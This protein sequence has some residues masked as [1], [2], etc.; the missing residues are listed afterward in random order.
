MRRRLA[1]AL[2]LPL[3]ILAGCSERDD[4]AAY[5]PERQQQL[6]GTWALTEESTY[7]AW[8]AC[9][10]GPGAEVPLTPKYRKIRDDFANI[11]ANDKPTPNNLAFCISPGVPG[12]FEHP[13]M[14]EFLLT[15]GRV[16]LIFH[17]GSF[18]RIWTDGRSFPESLTPTLQGYSIGRWEKNVLIV[19]TR[20]ISKKSDIFIEGYIKATNRTK[21]TERFAFESD[22]LIK[23]TVTVEDP[24]LFTRPFTYVNNFDKVPSSFEVGCA[25]DNRDTGDQ[26]DLTPPDDDE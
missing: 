6:A 17:D 4:D 19:E 16:N 12:T 13:L 5:S 26:V 9:C 15:P 18:R 24:E 23:M 21:V 1:P 25:V 11:P 20:G 14:F 2:I 3:L 8:A 10:D 7:R 22:N